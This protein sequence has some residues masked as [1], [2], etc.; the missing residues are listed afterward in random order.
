MPKPSP[1]LFGFTLIELLVVISII[2]ILVAIGAA[3]FS[4]AQK[5]ARDAKRRADMKAVQIALE[6]YYA[7]YS[8]YLDDGATPTPLAS[9]CNNAVTAATL[10]IDAP[11]TVADTVVKDPSSSS[12]YTCSAVDASF[13][14]CALLE[15]TGRGNHSGNSATCDT[16]AEL[17][18]GSGSYFCVESSQ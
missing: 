10:T 17:L 2:G 3:S 6:Q 7:V 8:S 11:G 12:N 9:G 1:R 16:T 4:A 18:A 5:G 15:I 14:A 13:C